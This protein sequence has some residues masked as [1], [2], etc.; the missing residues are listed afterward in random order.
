MDVELLQD[1]CLSCCDGYRPDWSVIDNGQVCRSKSKK[2]TCFHDGPRSDS[3]NGSSNQAR[4]FRIRLAWSKLDE[5]S[6]KTNLN[7]RSTNS[8]SWNRARLFRGAQDCRR[9][10]VVNN[11]TNLLQKGC[12]REQGILSLC[13]LIVLTCISG[14]S[15]RSTCRFRENLAAVIATV[16]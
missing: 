4:D 15:R 8:H 5:L 10:H 3:T 9:W 14:R 13:S 12:K 6:V 2:S 11:N 7:T 16:H 1:V